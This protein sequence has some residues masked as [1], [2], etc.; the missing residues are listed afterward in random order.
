MDPEG[1]HMGSPVDHKRARVCGATYW[2]LKMAGVPGPGLGKRDRVSL[3]LAGARN[4]NVVIP[5]R[6]G[7]K[8]ILCFSPANDKQRFN[9]LQARSSGATKQSQSNH[10]TITSAIEN[11]TRGVLL[12]AEFSVQTANRHPR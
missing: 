7:V 11:I 4:C 2:E 5:I 10:N 6:S 1:T 9:F 12:G 8:K 3:T